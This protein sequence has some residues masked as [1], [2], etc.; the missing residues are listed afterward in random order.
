MTT[1]NEILNTIDFLAFEGDKSL[2]INEIVNFDSE[3]FHDNSLLWCSDKYVENLSVVNHG[4]VILST[5]SF[6]NLKEKNQLKDTI[7]YIIVE[8][9]RGYFKEILT[10][11]FMP[12]P[13]F[14][15]IHKSATIHESATYDKDKVIIEP[16]V[17]LEEGVKI[18]NNV[19]IGANTIIK[20]ETVLNNNITIGCNNTIGGVGFGYE[21]N[22]NNEYEF[23]PHIGNVVICDGVEIGNNTCIDRAVIGSTII[24]D[25]VKIDNL[26]HIAHGVKIGKNS[27]IIAN[28]MIAGSVIIGENVW[29]SPSVSI[30]QKSI[31]EDDS[32]IGMG[33]VVIRN[34]ERSTIVA[35]VPAK[36]IKDK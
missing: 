5:K 32:L 29:V 36:K 21:Q 27:L 14:G 28:S 8:N 12:K 11:F 17:V 1:I 26:V 25:N 31:V 13:D 20:K 15:K 33:S 3:Q 18:G 6:N 23:I 22:I 10:R 9:P 4:C 7:N 16:N 24:G 35:G 30:I 19:I 2:E 34:V